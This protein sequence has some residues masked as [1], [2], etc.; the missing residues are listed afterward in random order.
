MLFKDFI[1]EYANSIEIFE[2]F[3]NIVYILKRHYALALVTNDYGQYTQKLVR[4]YNLN[5]YFS[6]ILS[7]GETPVRSP[8]S[9][10]YQYIINK[11]G[12]L[13]EETMI[14]VN[15][16]EADVLG[17]NILGDSFNQNQTSL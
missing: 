7:S 9:F 4:N 6:Y 3:L 11:V 1:E 14:V 2:D 16:H 5:N 17:A 10:L 13:P 15:K 8:D 12:C